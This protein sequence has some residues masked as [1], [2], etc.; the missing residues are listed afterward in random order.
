MWRVLRTPRWFERVNSETVLSSANRNTR[1]CACS[2]TL[3]H[4]VLIALYEAGRQNGIDERS[5][6]FFVDVL[7]SVDTIPAGPN[8]KKLIEQLA[9]AA[10]SRA[11]PLP[12]AL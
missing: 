3:A 11:S 6:R 10:G 9:A 5:H 2:K 1:K 12:F 7:G 4:R 8:T